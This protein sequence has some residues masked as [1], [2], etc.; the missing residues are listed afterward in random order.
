MVLKKMI[1]IALAIHLLGGYELLEQGVRFPALLAHYKEHRTL[2]NPGIS[3]LSFLKMH[4]ANQTHEAA[5][6]HHEQLP[7][8]H[9]HDHDCL[10]HTGVAI[11]TSHNDWSFAQ[12]LIKRSP[13]FSG[14]LLDVPQHFLEGIFQPP[15]A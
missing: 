12:F 2:E 8:K 14:L 1:L 10:C 11:Y 15:R 5:D 9:G 3:F 7:L 4:Y 13:L 6:K